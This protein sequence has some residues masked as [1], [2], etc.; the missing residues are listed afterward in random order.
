MV[1]LHIGEANVE[2]GGADLNDIHNFR[3]TYVCVY[4]TI[5]RLAQTSI[6]FLYIETMYTVLAEYYN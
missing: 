1:N 5:S 4:R 6:E 2:K 3:L